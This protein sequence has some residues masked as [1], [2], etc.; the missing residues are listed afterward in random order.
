MEKFRFLTAGES[1]GKCLTAIIEGLPAGIDIDSDF[2]NSELKR[3]QQGYGRGDRM[4]IESDTV[5]ITSGVR[6]GK[7]LGSPITLVIKN[8][9]FENWQKIMS[10]S[11]DDYTDDKSFSVFR[12]GHADYSGA[13]KYGQKDLRNIL[14]RSSARKT[15]IEVAVGAVAQLFLKQIGITGN[16]EVTQIGSACCPDKFHEEIDLTKEKGDSVGGKFVVTYKN[17]PV[18]LGSHVHWDRG[19]DGR[20]AQVIMSIPAIKVVEIGTNPLGFCGSEY[21]DEFDIKDD[22]ICRKTNHAGGIEGGITNGEDLIISGVMKPI[23]TMLKPLDS[24]DIKTKEKTQAHY[25][26]SDVCAVE[27]CAVVAQARVAW[28]L[29][30][31]ILLKFGSDSMEELIKRMA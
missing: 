8:K 9:D 15:A 1:H 23:P 29:A 7:T 5:E 18:G 28:V 4:K 21:H 3:R 26:R 16:S 31:E 12:P 25:E 27:S 20:L 10:V 19:I 6:F 17:I 30:N 22:K 2:I 13:I 24:V 14:E 11:P